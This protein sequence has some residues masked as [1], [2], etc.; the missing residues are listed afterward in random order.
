DNHYAPTDLNTTLAVADVVEHTGLRGVL[1]RG[2]V[3][4]HT[5]VAAQRGQ[6]TALF[7]YSAQEEIAITRAAMQHRPPGSKVEIWPA[8]LNLTYID[9]VLVRRCVE[10]AAEFGTGWHA[11]CCASSADPRTYFDAYGTT[12]VRW[13]SKNGLLDERATLAHAVWLDDAELPLVAEAGARIAHNPASNAYL[14]SGTLDLAA[15]RARGITVGLGTD[16]PRCGHRQDLFECMKQAVFAQRSSSHDP[17]AF[18]ASAALDL[19]TR[20]GAR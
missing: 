19:A 12:P 15:V 13:L 2:V 8:P 7:R 20:D 1:A 5:E 16:G 4:S 11:H 14:A 6:P 18:R 17:T 10:L 9:Q 3:G